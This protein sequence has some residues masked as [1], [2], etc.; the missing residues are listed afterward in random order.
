MTDRIEELAKMAYE[1]GH[2]PTSADFAD[3]GPAA[4]ENLRII[5]RTLY[6]AIMTEAWGVAGGEA[7]FLCCDETD[8]A[9]SRTAKRI[10]N[11]L[12]A[13]AKEIAP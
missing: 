4:K 8:D 13:K 2:H 11:A 9:V 1:A 5:V 6:A 3:I 10:A 12:L 7:P